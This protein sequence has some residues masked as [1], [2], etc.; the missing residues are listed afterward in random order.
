MPARIFPSVDFPA[1]FSP[2]RPWHSPRATANETS[3]GDLVQ[4]SGYGLGFGLTGPTQERRVGAITFDDAEE[5][6]VLAPLIFGDSG[7]PPLAGIIVNLVTMGDYYDVALRD[8][9]LLVGALA[10][11]VLATPGPAADRAGD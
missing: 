7:G 2:I 6:E 10:L 3:V 1:P 5:H 8:F 9:G 4:L 11:S